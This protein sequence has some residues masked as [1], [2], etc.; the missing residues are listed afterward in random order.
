MKKRLWIDLFRPSRK[1]CRKYVIFLFFSALLF[2][3]GL[4][5]NA[6]SVVPKVHEGYTEVAIGVSAVVPLTSEFSYLIRKN[7]EVRTNKTAVVKG[8]MLEI[9]VSLW[10]GEG[11]IL[12]QHH[13]AVH[14]IRA[15]GESAPFFEETN[16]N[17]SALFRLKLTPDT[18]GVNTIQVVDTTYG[19][20]LV[21]MDQPH[22]VVYETEDVKEKDQQNKKLTTAGSHLTGQTPLRVER[23]LESD[24][25][26]QKSVTIRIYQPVEITSRAGP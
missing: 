7:S 6:S 11:V 12:K 1:T 19:E 2:S 20:P 13:L 8:E 14:L 26:F 23:G 4:K 5:V 9:H 18:L 10:G 22:L 17:G 25:A 15:Q 21:L 16:E 24:D 3:S